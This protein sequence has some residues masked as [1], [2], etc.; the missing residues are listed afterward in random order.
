MSDLTILENFCDKMKCALSVVNRLADGSFTP[1]PKVLSL[2]AVDDN[3]VNRGN[4]NITPHRAKFTLRRPLAL[5]P[6]YLQRKKIV[7]TVL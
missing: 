2:L 4:Y 5:F 7:H 6:L 1:K 3:L